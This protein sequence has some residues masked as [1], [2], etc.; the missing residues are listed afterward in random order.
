VAATR[1]PAARHRPGDPSAPNRSSLLSSVANSLAVLELVVAQSEAGV[2][3]ISRRLGLT[4]GSV[5]RM[6]STLAALDYVEQNPTN[7]RY[8]PGPK[9]PDLARRLTGGRDFVVLARTHL[10]RLA[11]LTGETVN[12]GV[13]RE[14]EVVYVDRAVSDRPLAVS[15]QIGSRIPP[16]CTALGRAILASSP[17]ATVE[18]YL[19]HAAASPRPGGAAR[20]DRRAV[21]DLVERTRRDGVAVDDRE[22][23]PEIVCVAAPIVDATGAARAAVSVSLPASRSGDRIADLALLVAEA[24][25][26]LSELHQ[27]TGSASVW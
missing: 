19:D 20:F 5:Y 16:Y 14:H 25:K 23:S 4:V 26:E 15:V 1:L 10:E 6:L 13:L 7:R 24:G 8:R 18:A 21:A 9:I 11:A 22:F 17:A 2:S 3:E 12:L 27:L